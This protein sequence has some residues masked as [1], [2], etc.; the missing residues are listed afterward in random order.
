M[1][2][3]QREERKWN[4]VKC[5]IKIREGSKSEWKKKKENDIFETDVEI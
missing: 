1:T 5:T 3:N 2:E 4:Y